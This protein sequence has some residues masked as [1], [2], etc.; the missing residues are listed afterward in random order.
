M[1]HNILIAYFYLE[2]STAFANQN[3]IRIGRSLDDVS[4]KKKK[5]QLNYRSSIVK[6][7]KK[8]CWLLR[9]FCC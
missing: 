4:S 2:A 9:C 5:D 1:Q 7:C 8:S 3:D 6:F